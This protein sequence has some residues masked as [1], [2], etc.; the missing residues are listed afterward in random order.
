MESLSPLQRAYYSYLSRAYAF[1]FDLSQR[2]LLGI[3]LVALVRWIPIVILLWGWFKRWPGPAL[4]IL[5][6]IIIWLNYSLWRA[7]RDN[8]NRFVPA[9][10][11]LLESVDLEPL[12]PNQKVA[13]QATGLFSVS[14][15]ESVL[16]LRPAEYW[17]VPLG[18]H[19]IMV[20]EK[21]GKYLYQFFNAQSL[22]NVRPGWLLFGPQPIE[23][24]AVTFLARWGPEYTRFGQLY[25]DGSDEGLPPP[26]Q[27]TVYLSTPDA[28]ARRVIWQTIVSDARRTR[29]GAA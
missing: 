14:G 24:L 10:G 26:K 29:L 6:L 12:P 17:R 15:R 16:L 22:Q 25:E 7:K 1:M 21:A 5:L 13:L 20:E 19:V 2:S 27:V 3:R 28:D 8:Y 9:A 11:S 18:E 23:S 4:I